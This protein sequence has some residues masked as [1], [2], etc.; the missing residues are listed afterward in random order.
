MADKT[1]TLEKY[2]IVL[3]ELTNKKDRCI[4]AYDPRL[5]ELLNKSER[6]ID[7][8]LQELC[9]VFDAIVV[10]PNSTPK[11]YKLLKPIDLFEEAY[12]KYD[13]LEWLFNLL[14]EKDPQIFDKLTNKAQIDHEIYQFKNTPLEDIR[15]IESKQTFKNLKVAV[16]N[17]EYRDISFKD[18]KSYKDVKCIKLIFMEGNWYIAYITNE[19]Q[20]KFGRIN[21]IKEVRYSKK[22][23]FQKSSVKKE[24]NF[25]KTKLQNPFTLYDT[26]PQIATIKALPSIAQ[27]FEK[28][29]KKFLSSQKFIKKEKDGS[30]IFEVSYTQE[31]EILP[32]VQKWMPDLIIQEPKEL[33]QSYKNKLERA[34][35]NYDTI[36]F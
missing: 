35:K 15:S 10:L 28:D 4:T 22:N 2:I 18:T 20:L 36:P 11:L 31:M 33:Q 23:S 6:Q 32:F 9:D 30:I 1:K 26:K 12:R 27:Y 13:D 5:K 24:L 19:N 34:L 3:N 7:R 17:R 25:I 21:F 8:I 14:Q 16:K 29:M